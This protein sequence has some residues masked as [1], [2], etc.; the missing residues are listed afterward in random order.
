MV[1]EDRP[2]EDAIDKARILQG[3]GRGSRGA[4]KREPRKA[5]V[6]VKPHVDPR[7]RPRKA[8][9]WQA[10]PDEVE[11]ERAGGGQ[12]AAKASRGI[13]DILRRDMQ[14]GVAQVNPE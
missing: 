5:R 2:F 14:A 10:D 9:L 3:E 13:V 12:A 4:G 11:V 1:G 7:I 8:A 6:E